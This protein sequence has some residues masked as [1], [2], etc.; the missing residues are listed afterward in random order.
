[1]SLFVGEMFSYVENSKELTQ[2]KKKNNP[3]NS[4]LSDYSKVV[5]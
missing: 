4:S 3:K 1:M 5:G 2:K